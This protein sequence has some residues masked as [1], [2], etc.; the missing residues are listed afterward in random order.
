MHYHNNHISIEQLKESPYALINDGVHN[1]RLQSYY[2]KP[3]VQIKQLSDRFT[4]VSVYSSSTGARITDDIELNTTDDS[5][6]Y[7]LCKIK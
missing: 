7:Y 4:D 6:L 5:W 3:A 2:I 1:F